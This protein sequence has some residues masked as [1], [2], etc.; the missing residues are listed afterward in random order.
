M[1]KS[2][3]LTSLFAFASWGVSSAQESTNVTLP[4]NKENFH[5]FLLMGQSNMAGHAPVLPDDRKPQKDIFSIPTKGDIKW[6]PAAHPLHNRLPK[7]DGF[8]LGISFAKTYQAS[9]PGVT[10][11]FIPVAWGGAKIDKLNKGKETYAD[12]IKKAEFAKKYGVIK[13]VLWHQGESDTVKPKLSH[14]YGKKLQKLIA[15]I[16]ADLNQPKL[17]FIVGDLCPGYSMA[18]D[19]NGKEVWQAGI[20]EVK[21]ILKEIP[22]KV[23]YTGF[24]SSDGLHYETKKHR[25]HF[26]RD[27]YIELG[28]RYAKVFDSVVSE[29]K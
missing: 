10:V 24:V 26:D 13:G 16:R 28:K 21:K 11:G 3:L 8:G 15:D 9:H 5:I 17:P 19:K 2:I 23:K 4:K 14:T 12:A 22:S 18:Q 29:Q 27:S 7:S 20:K 6:I 1:F 25:V